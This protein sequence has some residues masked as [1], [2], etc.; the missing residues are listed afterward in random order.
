MRHARL[1]VLSK[2]DDLVEEFVDSKIRENTQP[3]EKVDLKAVDA[4]FKA[5]MDAAKA[6]VVAPVA[7][8]LN[9]RDAV[10]MTKAKTH[11]RLNRTLIKTVKVKLRLTFLRL[12]FLN[13]QE[14]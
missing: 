11:Q 10:V 13:S 9:L 2:D 6:D 3:S 7:N 14:M 5:Y 12:R 8:S 1:Q 4:K